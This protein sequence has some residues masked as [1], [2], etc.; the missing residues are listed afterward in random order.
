MPG[1]GSVASGR[2]VGYAQATLAVV[3]LLMTMSFGV[4]FI[5]WFFS[6]WSR[7]NDYS[8]DDPFAML[9]EVWHAARW[10]LLSMVIFAI[11]WLW[12]LATSV[13]LL[14]QSKMA[15]PAKREKAPPKLADLPKAGKS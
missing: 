3:G 15:E 14:R 10:P 2:A 4:R 9:S 13:S 11:A 7:L 6:N 12:A 5:I 8:Q 1:S